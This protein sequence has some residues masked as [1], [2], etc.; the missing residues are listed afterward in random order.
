MLSL[1][2]PGMGARV[3]IALV[4]GMGTRVCIALVSG[5]VTRVCYRSG[6]WYGS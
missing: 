6:T 4:P 3:C 1:W 2:V 5:M